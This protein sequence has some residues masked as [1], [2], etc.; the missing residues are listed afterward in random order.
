MGELDLEIGKLFRNGG[1]QA[2]RL[3]A[4]CRVDGAEVFVRKMSGGAVMLIPKEGIRG[5]LDATFGHAT[6]SFMKDGRPE[7]VESPRELQ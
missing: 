3:P 6:E 1:S 7:F 2:V 5:I 4:D